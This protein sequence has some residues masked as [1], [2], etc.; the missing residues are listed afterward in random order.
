VRE[1]PIIFSAESVRAILEGRKTQ[2]RR[3]CKPQPA[4]AGPNGG[5]IR[6]VVKSL[7]SSRGDLFDVRY[8]L[9]NPGTL[10]SEHAPGDRLWVRETWGPCAGGVV[11]N[12]DDVGSNVVCPDGGRWKPTIYMPRWASR[13]DL[14]ITD[15]RV[16]RLQDITDED[17]I[18]EGV[19]CWECNGPVDGTSENGCG[20]FHFAQA[21]DA[22]NGKRATW[23]S[24]PWVW[25]LTFRRVRKE[26]PNQETDAT[27]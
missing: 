5:P 8:D 22:I 2:T 21:W 6:E 3:L 27:H 12:A 24:N 16:Q 18:A 10:R 11:Y 9:D 4:P 23:S 19:R 15:V 26:V 25:A 7:L 14:E 13:I 1:R 17:A 20:C